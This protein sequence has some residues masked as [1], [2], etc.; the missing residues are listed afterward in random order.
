MDNLKENSANLVDPED[1][2]SDLISSLAAY[3]TFT[4]YDSKEYL[5]YDATT[6]E[7]GLGDP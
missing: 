4:F 2:E 6:D 1:P 5:R 3:Y 7:E